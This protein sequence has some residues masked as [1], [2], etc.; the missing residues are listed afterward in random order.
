M[1]VGVFVIL[2]FYSSIL[3]PLP[4][5]DVET[6]NNTNYF[7]KVHKLL[8]NAKKSICLIMFSAHYYDRFKDSP[9]NI[10]LMD[11]ASAKKRGL[12]VKVVLEQEEP[13]KGLSKK[14]KIYP[15]QH[16]RVTAFLK[17]NN[18]PY[19]LDSPSVTT[20]AKLIIIDEIYTVIGSTNWS[21]SALSKNN[22]TAV[23][24]KS[25]EVSRSYLDYFEYIGKK[26]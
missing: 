25:K 20:H 5:E 2:V 1:K 11:L 12:D 8:Q 24:I 22:E 9:S 10:L 3:Y 17:Q 26:L 23:I 16:E 7:P 21:Y 15:E 19:V 14:K 6:I 13:P 18:I 4:A